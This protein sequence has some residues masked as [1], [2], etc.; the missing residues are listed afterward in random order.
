MNEVDGLEVAKSQALKYVSAR[1]R[2]KREVTDYLSKK[3]YENAVIHDV[4]LF[5]E[6]YQYLN[7]EA[8]CRAWIH[9]KMSFHPCGRKKMEVELLKKVPNRQLVQASLEFCFSQEQ[10]QELVLEAAQ[11]KLNS[12]VGKKALTKE[13]LARFLYSRGYGSSMIA[14]ALEHVDFSSQ[15]TEF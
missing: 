2:T 13:Q 1:L 4:I 12:R 3:G 6:R 7:D 14:F 9:D 5:L 8:Y 11:Q 10:E 15:Q